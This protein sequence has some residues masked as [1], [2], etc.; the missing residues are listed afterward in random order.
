MEV[1][2]S[3]EKIFSVFGIPVSNTMLTAWVVVLLLS[4][5]SYFATRNMQKIPRGMQN[6]F[7]WVVES[8]F[9]LVESFMGDRKQTLKIFPLAATFFFF[10]LLSNWMG[11]LPGFGSIGIHE[12]GKFLPIFRSATADLNTTLAFAMIS[13]IIIQISGV[14]S[15]GFF[16]YGKKF[17]N[18][19]SPINFFV[20]LLEIISELAKIV[21]FSFRLFGSVFAGEVLLVVITGL[22][23]WI[24]PLP[25]YGLEL[26]IGGIQAVVFMLLTVVFIKI[27]TT[28]MAH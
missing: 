16:K 18:F 28:E 12:H 6:F 24:I 19:S 3:A 21:S 15:L 7:E 27:A 22:V 11:L 9:G 14:V 25:F 20:G 5:S 10:I 8:L 26:F 2:V 1:S 4:I 17:I 23:P 13:V